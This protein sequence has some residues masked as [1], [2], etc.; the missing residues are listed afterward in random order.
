MEKEAFV[1]LS[2]HFDH[3]GYLRCSKHLEVGEKMM[4]FLMVLSHNSTN[5]HI[6]WEFQHS[7]ETVSKYF[8]EVLLGMIEF[9]REMIVPPAWD[10][11]MGPIRI[12]RRLREGAFRGA[13]GALDGT[14]IP[15]V[16]PTNRQIPYRARGGKECYQNVMAIC[17]FDMK[18]LFVVAGWE[19]VAHDARIL[20]ET[21]RD[22]D[23]NFPM[24]PADKYYLCDAAYTHSKGFMGPYRRTR[25]WLAD[26]IRLR[27]RTK[28]ERFNHAHVR[29]RNVIERSFGVL[30]ARF[31]ILQTMRPFI[32]PIQRNMVIACMAIHNFIR[33]FTLNDRLFPQFEHTNLVLPRDAASTSQP[34]FTT[35]DA[36]YMVNLRDHIA[37]ELCANMQ[38]ANVHD[39][40]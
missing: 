29:L 20:N 6:K 23:F 8:H 25:Y 16:I 11:P 21:V 1:L 34:L 18:F 22:P 5:R 17:D 4:I 13:V 15:A 38:D 24:P 2:N 36:T 26:F 31:L 7:G 3:R 35:Q 10:E 33:R 9:S 27:A 14:L 19:G 39:N 30:K 40:D 28:Q 32:F 37:N 12:H